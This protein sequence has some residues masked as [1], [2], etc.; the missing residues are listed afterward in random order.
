MKRDSMNVSL[1][2]DGQTGNRLAKP[3]HEEPD[4]GNLHVRVCEGL[5]RKRPRLLGKNT[6]GFVMVL[7]VTMSGVLWASESSHDPGVERY[8]VVWDSPCALKEWPLALWDIPR[9][10]KAGEGW[11][12]VTGSN[13]FVPIRAP[14]TENLNGIWEVDAK[15]GKSEYNLT[16]TTP[17]RAPQSQDIR[18]K[19]VQAKVFT[20]DGQT[21]AYIWPMQP[22]DA[23]FELS[24]PEGKSALYYD[25]PKCERVD[26]PPGKHRLTIN[27]E[28]W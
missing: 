19:K 17:K 6:T 4:A 27:N 22:R 11:W 5:G 1:E 16:I 7:M 12:K 25:T 14:Y 18:L 20:R 23:E 9:E 2:S 24:V 26:L 10:W 15:P 21:M 8:N 28:S 13:R 3:S